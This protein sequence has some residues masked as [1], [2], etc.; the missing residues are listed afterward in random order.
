MAHM[1]KS[2]T[3]FV[4][5]LGLLLAAIPAWDVLD[6]RGLVVGLLLVLAWV[7]GGFLVG[8]SIWT[9]LQQAKLAESRQA[10]VDNE[11]AETIAQLTLERNSA[12]RERKAVESENVVLSTRI[13]KHMDEM[14]EK[15]AE[16]R[17]VLETVR[18]LGEVQ[19]RRIERDTFVSQ[20][21]HLKAVARRIKR[22]CPDSD[23][24]IR[25]LYLQS[26]IPESTAQVPPWLKLATDWHREMMTLSCVFDRPGRLTINLDFESVMELLD[27]AVV[28]RDGNRPLRDVLERSPELDIIRWGT[29]D[30]KPDNSQT[31]GFFVKNSGEPASQV[32]I[33]PAVSIGEYK[34]TSETLSILYS[35]H[36]E[37]FLR[38]YLTDDKQGGL[39][40]NVLPKMLSEGFRT[41]NGTWI[42]PYV[43]LIYQ[44]TSGNWY[45]STHEI[46]LSTDKRSLVIS[47]IRREYLTL[48]GVE[49]L[50]H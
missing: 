4:T 1:S 19:T 34:M 36:P 22:A 30:D 41:K 16:Y 50:D 29:V 3:I 6:H 28:V 33:Y 14:Q 40:P 48:P 12:A 27:D 49:A 24:V 5:V 23:F 47:R 42:P 20:I 31:F 35:E 10:T 37:G 21:E 43:R 15:D 45:G 26:W 25:P 39:V 32:K 2:Q 46:C 13:G 7:A 18:N 38:V 44:S 9:N 11:S 8:Y 17:K